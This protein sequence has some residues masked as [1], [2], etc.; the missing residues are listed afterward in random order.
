MLAAVR[1]ATALPDAEL[2]FDDY[3][4]RFDV[5]PLTVLTDGAIAVFG[6]DRRRLRPNIVISGVGGL[7]E[8]TWPGRMLKIGGG[9][10]Y[11][12]VARSRSRCVMTTFD[13]DTLEQNRGVLQ[14]IVDDLDARIA[15]DCSVVRG[16]T[17]RV[18]HAVEVVPAT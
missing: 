5:L 13:P 9:A 2:R 1:E 16:G 6:Y 12:A 7:L 4:E 3:V 14:H 10:A 17:I 11:V 18:G 8:K 15:L